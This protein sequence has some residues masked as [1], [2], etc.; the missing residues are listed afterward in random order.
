MT[1]IDQFGKRE[2]R[3]RAP[4][5]FFQQS[6]QESASHAE[7]DTRFLSQALA[8]FHCFNRSRL[9]RNGLI[10]AQSKSAEARCAKDSTLSNEYRTA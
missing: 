5:D 1:E 7:I 9:A 4:S 8:A 2:Y 3:P 6:F 10:P